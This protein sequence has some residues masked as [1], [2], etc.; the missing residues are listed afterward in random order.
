MDTFNICFICDGHH[1][2]TECEFYLSFT[3]PE[4]SSRVNPSTLT[5][6]TYQEVTADG[7]NNLWRE[8]TETDSSSEEDWDREIRMHGASPPYRLGDRMRQ[9]VSYPVAEH[10]LQQPTT[11]AQHD[12][13]RGDFNAPPTYDECFPNGP[14][15]YAIL[16]EMLQ[17]RDICQ[18]LPTCIHCQKCC[19]I[20]QPSRREEHGA[21]QSRHDFR[22]SNVG[23]SLHRVTEL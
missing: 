9:T 21:Q 8:T 15:I 22:H 3:V 20:V 4:H 18:F 16:R 6:T 5:R 12:E 1:E 7:Q 13:V 14:P 10:H 17:H 19:T 23:N 11:Y 2:E